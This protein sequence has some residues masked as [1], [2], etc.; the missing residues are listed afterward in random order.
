ML[1]WL[2][3]LAGALLM[4][5]VL[6]D[7]FLT[8]LYARAGTGII[9]RIH[10]RWTW[11]LFRA[12]SRP[13]GR[14][15]GIILSFAGPVILVSLVLLW[16]FLLAVGAALIIHPNLGASVRANSG[17]TPTNFIAALYAAG[18]S[19]SLVGASN[20]S[21]QTSGFRLLYLF[22]SI[23]GTAV[24]SL[25]LTYLMQVYNALQRRN[26]LGLNLDLASAGTGDA[27]ELIA[28]LGPEGKFD[29]GYSN[30]SEIAGDVAGAK[31][32]H[33]FYPVLFYFRFDE[34]FYSM[35]RTALVALD[36]V[37]LI[38]S[39]LDDDEYAWLK[40]SAAV[41]Q[42]WRASMLLIK[43][44]R[45]TFLSGNATG[46]QAAPDAQTLDGWHRRYSAAL[47]RLGQAGLKTRGDEQAGANLYVSLRAEWDHHVKTLAAAL[48]YRVEEIDPAGSRPQSVDERQ[49]FSARLHSAG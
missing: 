8:V 39:A 42:L 3:H 35:S 44:L 21:P 32:S 46:L 23:I 16:A 24:T 1:R 14:D 20:F 47:R 26:K 43:T 37:T 38:K 36:T 29:A 19:I 25:T 30:L 15:R 48:A 12:V 13:F 7:V 17:E 18:S 33:H 40:E 34:P 11:S 2:E 4:L 9:S 22:N 28:D 41:A 31:E 5:L 49:E 45:D 27:A 6:L 10:A